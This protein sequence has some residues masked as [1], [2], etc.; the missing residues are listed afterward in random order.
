MYYYKNNPH[1]AKSINTALNHLGFDVGVNRQIHWEIN[2]EGEPNDV[3]NKM[4]DPKN[5][6][7]YV[8]CWTCHHGKIEPEHIRPVER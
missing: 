1:E 6:K 2:I 5:Y 8:T 7:T 4:E 3:L